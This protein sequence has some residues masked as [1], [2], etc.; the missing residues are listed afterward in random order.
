MKKLITFLMG[1]L[2]LS[3]AVWAVPQYLSYS[4]RLLQQGRLATGAKVMTWKIY[5]APSG[6]TLL[7]S[8]ANVT[9]S[10]YNGIYGVD[11]GPIDSNLF[12][13]GNSVYLET[14][15]G[16]ETLLPRTKI[17]SVVYALQAGGL[18][19]NCAS[20]SLNTAG[21]LSSAAMSASAPRRRITNLKWRG[22]C[23]RVRRCL[24]GR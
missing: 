5:D 6:G 21:T 17:N 19:D 14:T 12:S 15:V 18:A 3:A 23:R 22:R 7:W 8:T 20:V 13:N 9:T 2:L 11:L 10:V 16:A 24:M 1:V 4:G